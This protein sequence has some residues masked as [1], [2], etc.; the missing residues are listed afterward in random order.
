VLAL[1]AVRHRVNKINVGVV[2][3]GDIH[4]ADGELVVLATRE[5]WPASCSNSSLNTLGLEASSSVQGPLVV[6]GGK[7]ILAVEATKVE[8]TKV[9]ESTRWQFSPVKTLLLIRVALVVT[10]VRVGER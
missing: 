1:G 10:V 7:G 8:S 4:V 2:G 6:L 5:A 3:S 9:A